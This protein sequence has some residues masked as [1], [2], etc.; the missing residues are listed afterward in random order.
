MIENLNINKETFKQND[1]NLS[2]KNIESSNL[3]SNIQKY[4]TFISNKSK[5]FF[6][7]SQK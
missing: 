6:S 2:E 5:N 1:I 4:K 7:T 3:P